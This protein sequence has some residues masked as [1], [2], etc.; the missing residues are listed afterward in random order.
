M[1]RKGFLALCLVT[2]V[3]VALAAVGILS[4]P[5]LRS[6]DVAG[7][8]LFPG[9]AQKLGSLKSVVVK[10]ADGDLTFDWDGKTWVV[11]DRKNYP[12]DGDKIA[13]IVLQMARMVKL[14]A[15][16]AAAD[17][18]DRLDLTDPKA[19][20]SRAKEIVLL[21]RDGKTLADLIVGK[22]KFTLGSKEGGT[23]VRLP[24]SN[25]TWLALGDITAG[26]KPRDW[27]K[28]DMVDIKDRDVKRV[29]VTHPDGE[30]VVAGKLTPADPGFKIENLPAGKQ[31][32]SDYAADD[33]G[34]LVA[35]MLADDVARAD[36]IPFPKDK[37]TTA[38]VDTFSGMRVTLQLAEKDG[39][40]WVKLKAE[41]PPGTPA[42]APKPAGEGK[43]GES[44]TA[45]PD[46]AKMAAE[47]NARSDGW[48]YEVPA[49]EVA[50]MR[51]RM[52]ELIKKP[53][54]K[55]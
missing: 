15:K 54:T 46:W 10:Q 5:R 19:K 35:A 30:K 18:L 34:R 29:T 45:G 52:A 12:A 37:T 27:L 43:L 4:Q 33:Y 22:R 14:E 23:Y 3:F 48:V 47:I 38:D 55:S 25:Q 40:S 2:A 44:A 1:T 36:D 32:A 41:P 8:P 16:T 7:E 31:P 13:G 21:D 11:R 39:K 53:E 49:Y 24:G 50:A 9:L 6:P 20:D 17:K 42:P 26:A 51:K 28:R